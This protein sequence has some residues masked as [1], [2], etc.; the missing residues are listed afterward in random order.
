MGI[1]IG[2]Q[3]YSSFHTD[4]KELEYKDLLT[5]VFTHAELEG[6]EKLGVKYGYPQWSFHNKQRVNSFFYD[7]YGNH[8]Q[9]CQTKSV[10]SQI[11]EWVVYKLGVLNCPFR[12]TISDWSLLS[13]TLRYVSFGEVGSICRV[14]LWE[15]I[16]LCTCVSEEGDDGETVRS[17]TPSLLS[18]K[19]LFIINR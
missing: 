6:H 18:C 13:H 7:S 19:G 1:R 4:V 10:D 12:N 17:E 15:P 16:H 2:I 14:P 3:V 5:N 8:S 9:T 11:H